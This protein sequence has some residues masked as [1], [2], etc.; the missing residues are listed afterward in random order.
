MS[1]F[2]SS[3]EG[4]LVAPLKSEINTPLTLEITFLGTYLI[5]LKALK[6]K[7]LTVRRLITIL[8]IVT[9]YWVGGI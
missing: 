6:H 4:N 9:K 3:S 1:S 5:K 8:F 2:I 7:T